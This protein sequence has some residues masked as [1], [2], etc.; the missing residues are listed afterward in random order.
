LTIDEKKNRQLEKMKATQARARQRQRDKLNDPEYREAQRQKKI[1]AIE[2]RRNKVTEKK[3]ATKSK[4]KTRKPI[5][6]KGLKGR[7]PSAYERHIM[8][9]IGALPCV[10]CRRHGRHAPV[11]S[12]HHIDG[13]TAFM[14]HAKV[15]PLCAHHHNVAASPDVINQYPDLIPIH[16]QGKHGGKAQWMAHNGTEG[17]LLK[18]ILDELGVD[19]GEW[20]A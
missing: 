16:A 20:V 2:K 19:F 12:L 3:L 18:E 11:I 14:A 15:L 13:R 10:A 6:S 5:K 7:T 1:A 17:E 8:N 4:P 9:A